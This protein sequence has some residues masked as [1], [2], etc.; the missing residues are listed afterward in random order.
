[1]GVLRSILIPLYACKLAYAASPPV[2]VALRSSWAA[3]HPLVEILCVSVL[4]GLARELTVRSGRLSRKRI[5]MHSS[6]SS[7]H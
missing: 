7:M 2:K 6:P 5:K 3:P 4:S 1:M